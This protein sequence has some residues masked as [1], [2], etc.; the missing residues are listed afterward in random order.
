MIGIDT[1]LGG[2]TGLIGSIWTSYNQRKL[3]EMRIT[4]K[5]NQ[6]KHDLAMIKAN[7]EATIAEVNANIERDTIQY[8]AIQDLA[9]TGAFKESIKEGNKSLFNSDW[10]AYL[11]AEGHT[12][13]NYFG[14][15]L[16]LIMGFIDCIRSMVRPV[17]TGYSLY[18]FASITWILTGIVMD[19]SNLSLLNALDYSNPDHLNKA[20][21]LLT[22]GVTQFQGFTPD[23]AMHL[24]ENTVYPLLNYITSS[25]I[26]WWFGERLAKSAQNKIFNNNVNNK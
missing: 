6:R 24:L 25:T 7:T 22:A 13:R 2:L 17:I 14:M 1:L 5:E 11:L 21:K 4:D 8:G 20:V 26:L 16:C 10:M 19:A 9:Q 3:E 12:V 18:L 23:K 15:F